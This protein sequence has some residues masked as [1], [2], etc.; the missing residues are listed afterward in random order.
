MYIA[1][2]QNDTATAYLGGSSTAGAPEILKTTNGGGTWA[3]AFFSTGNQNIYT[4]WSGDGGDRSWGYGE[5]VYGITAAP[6]GGAHVVFTD[7]GFVHTSTDGGATWREAYCTPA[8]ENPP[9][10]STPRGKSYRGCG[11]EVTSCWQVVWTGPSNLFACFTD[12]EGVRSTDGGASWSF[13]Y[14]PRSANTMYRIARVGSVLYA[15]TSNVHDMYQSTRLQDAQLDSTDLQGKIIRSTDGGA[16]WSDIHYFGH[17]VFWLAADPNV[18][19][20]MYASVIHSS[21]GGVFVTNDLQD[22]A[23][24]VWTRLPSPPRTQGHPASL[25]VLN[26]GS[27][28]CSFSGRRT[29]QGFTQSSG[30][31]VYAPG[32][33]T[34][35]DV[36]DPGMLYWTKDVTV[37]P[38]DSAQR[39][40]YAGV[41]SG[42]GGPPNGLG[43]LY[44]T[45]NRGSSWT[46]INAL[47]RVTSLTINPAKAAEA[48]LTTETEGLWHT[49]TLDQPSPQ[50][51][52]DS[53]YPFRQPERVFY[54]PYTPGEIWVTSFGAGMMARS[55]VASLQA[56]SGSG[57]P[58]EI[59]LE[60]NYPNPF[61]PETTIRY[62][63][64]REMRVTLI[65]YDALGRRVALLVD[66]LVQP[67][68][69]DVRVHASALASGM[70]VYTLKGGGFIRSKKLLVIR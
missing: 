30:V 44:R 6:D 52:V 40:W 33:G 31:F 56:S 27:L 46:R 10:A 36:S 64:P 21:L 4:G 32:T 66:G 23:A 11:L 48:W 53:A 20:R 28:V 18:T 14:S 59:M 50:F 5:C 54:N 62:T 63:V 57:V 70:Y 58:A 12:I 19:G 49:L 42:W 9:M 7:M 29:S 41:F 15:A 37:D 2:P 51:A 68:P 16:T 38:F 47:D 67:G 1:V 43:G 39:R 61:N 55:P 8:D 69:H 35:Q 17:P 34:W 26:D 13:N 3:Q 24:S 60:Q 65:L 45:T 22:G 25:G